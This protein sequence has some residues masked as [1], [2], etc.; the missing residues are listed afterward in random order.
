MVMA[1]KAAGSETI[2]VENVYAELLSLYD[3]QASDIARQPEHIKPVKADLRSLKSFVSR[4]KI[5]FWPTLL[6]LKEALANWSVTFIAPKP[7]NNVAGILAKADKLCKDRGHALITAGDVLEAIWAAPSPLIELCLVKRDGPGMSKEFAAKQ[8][9]VILLRRLGLGS[10]PQPDSDQSADGK[11]EGSDSAP[12]KTIVNDIA[13]TLLDSQII[14]TSE[15]T[16]SEPAPSESSA[17][18]EPTPSEP[19]A[20]PEPTPLEPAQSEPPAPPEAPEATPLEPAQSEPPAPPEATPPEPAQSEPPAAPEATPPEPAQS[21]PPVSPEATPPEPM[22]SEPRVKRANTSKA[23]R[24]RN[25]DIPVKVLLY[26]LIFCTL[27]FIAWILYGN[28][29]PFDEPWR[30]TAARITEYVTAAFIVIGYTRIISIKSKA[31]CYFLETLA[32]IALVYF[33]V[34]VLSEAAGHLVL[35]MIAKIIVALFG[36]ALGFSSMF[37]INALSHS[38]RTLKTGGT[39]SAMFTGYLLRSLLLPG[40]VFSIYWVWELRVTEFWKTV[41]DIFAFLWVFDTLRVFILSCASVAKANANVSMSYAQRIIE[42]LGIQIYVL[43][44]PVFAGFLFWYFHCLPVKNWVAVLYCVYGIMWV[45][46]SWYTFS[47]I[48]IKDIRY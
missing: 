17:P 47:N 46:A 31:V 40:L 21:E 32:F 44:P 43:F 36:L 18:P 4:N 34:S 16:P 29:F 42:F 8:C 1:R 28:R 20:A 12:V 39:P 48:I 3:R 10:L 27:G 26:P 11:A 38:G 15:P 13:P 41:F 2:S 35:P 6:M 24:E 14:T 30:I 7:D 23:I 25:Y 5:D 9:S 33:C 19:P 45:F 22:P 37:K